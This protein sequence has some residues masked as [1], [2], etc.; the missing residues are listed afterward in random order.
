MA[1]FASLVT[2]RKEA[3]EI[4]SILLGRRRE[5]IPLTRVF[6]DLGGS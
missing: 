1:F 3:M 2:R 4:P 5:L 6:Q